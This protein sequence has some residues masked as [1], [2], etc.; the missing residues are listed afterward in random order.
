MSIVVIM[1][2]TPKKPQQPPLTRRARSRHERELRR[3]RLVIIISGFAIGLALLAVLIGVAYDQVWVPSRPVAQV[4]SATLSRR[5]YWAERRNDLARQ[6]GQNMKNLALLG[7]LG[8]Q[9]S[10]QLA[11]QIPPLNEEAANVRSAA[12]DDTTINSWIDRQL[13]AQAAAA[14]NIQA[15]NGEIAQEML[16]DLGSAFPPPAPPPT[17]TATLEP[18]AIVTSTTETTATAE[19]SATATLAPTVTPGG[20]TATSA[21]TETPAPTATLAPS[22]TPTATPLPDAAL[23]EVDAVIGR[24]FDAYSNEI[25]NTGGKN[26]FTID[27]FKVALQEQYL[28]QV[29]TRKVEAQLL[30]ETS[31]TPGT[32]P[33]NIETRHILIAV[34]TPISATEAE[35]E[36]A[37]AA[38]KPDAEAILQQL[39]G[40]ADF[41]ALAAEKSDDATTKESGGVLPGFDKDGA[42]QE[43]MAVDPA[44]VKAALALN[45][46][47][48]SD[49]IRTPFG[50]HIIQL[51][52]RTVP[53]P[54]D[55]L[56]EA[57]TKKFEEWLSQQRA[58]AT[59]EHFPA[60]TPEPTPLPTQPVTAPPLPTVSLHGTPTATPT[61]TAVPTATVTLPGTPMATPAQ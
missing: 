20:P 54:A 13:I 3:Q 8:P 34:T 38:R 44:I 12:V 46:G 27:D 10:Q 1:A 51:D 11:G 36:A 21:P 53:S 22:E 48:I 4:N 6:V 24:L 52:K 7:S 32:D 60:R 49:L 56:Q 19:V 33:S 26:N 43:G 9:F 59:V 37:Y 31:F 55:Q 30:P 16:A 28:R 5:D 25:L 41:A 40:G 45:E 14:M 47:Q 42:T 23:A 57:R 58:A 2:Q 29:L 61:A 35:R 39:R 50:W 17:T 18:T 15:D